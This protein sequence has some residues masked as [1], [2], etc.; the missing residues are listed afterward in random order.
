MLGGV[1]LDAVRRGTTQRAVLGY[2]LA[3]HETGN[4]YMTEAVRAVL[5]FAFRELKLHRVE[6]ASIPE[7]V[8]SVR[9]LERA[10]FTREGYMNSYI[11]IDGRWEDHLLFA[12]IDPD[13]ATAA[14]EK[15]SE[16]RKRDWLG[17]KVSG[18]DASDAGPGKGATKVNAGNTGNAGEAERG[19]PERSTA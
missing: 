16:R 10:G 18:E 5:G 2:W 19:T 8:P 12:V 13:G 15:G 17:R 4:G 3:E 14:P 11:R 7:N 1:T 9:V 6:A